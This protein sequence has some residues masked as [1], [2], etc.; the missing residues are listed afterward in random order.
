M[1]SIT[2]ASLILL[3]SL[4]GKAQNNGPLPD[5]YNASNFTYT[6]ARLNICFKVPPGWNCLSKDAVQKF[7]VSPLKETTLLAIIKNNTTTLAFADYDLKIAKC[8][9]EQLMANLKHHLDSS[10]A[11]VKTTPNVKGSFLPIASKKIGSYTFSVIECDFSTSNQPGIQY[12]HLV[13]VRPTVPGHFFSA[14]VNIHDPKDLQALE[15]A[16]ACN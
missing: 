8:T 12:K 16:L 11:W 10:F 6:N 9:K 4:I 2:L 14:A 1:R 7:K 13:Y 3:F 5:G 15:N